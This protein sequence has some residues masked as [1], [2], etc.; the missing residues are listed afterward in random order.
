ME[1]PKQSGKKSK[2]K[3][4][5]AEAKISINTTVGQREADMFEKEKKIVI[6]QSE[7][8]YYK[9]RTEGTSTITRN[10]GMVNSEIGSNNKGVFGNNRK[11]FTNKPAFGVRREQGEPGFGARGETGG[12]IT[13]NTEPLP[14]SPVKTA[15]GPKREFTNPIS[16]GITRNTGN[17]S[18]KPK[19]QALSLG[20]KKFSNSKK[21]E[22]TTETPKPVEVKATEDVWGDKTVKPR[23]NAWSRNLQ[24]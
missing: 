11:E 16:S 10:N 22:T 17:V 8:S 4:N 23:T 18:E 12:A 24:S 20:P 7:G 9:P 13:R 1:A 21:Q 14:D 2:K 5:K 3:W 15:F 19:D 6:T